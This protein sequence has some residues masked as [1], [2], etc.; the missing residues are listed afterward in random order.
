M[1][2]QLAEK[3]VKQWNKTKKVKQPKQQRTTKIDQLPENDCNPSKTIKKPQ[4]KKN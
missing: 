1:T 2:K 3:K 4:Q